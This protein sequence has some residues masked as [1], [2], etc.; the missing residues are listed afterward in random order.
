[1]FRNF[2]NRIW[3]RYF[4]ESNPEVDARKHRIHEVIFESHTPQGKL[5]DVV[6]FLVIIASVLVVMLESIRDLRVHYGSFFYFLEW[7]F[8]LFFTIEYALRVYC[9]KKP[10]VY[11]F[12]FF[13][14]IDLLA[15]LP[16]YI[17]W[18][19]PGAQS[20]LVIRILRLLRIFRVFRL[21]QYFSEGKY[22]VQAM[23]ASQRKI[24]V[25]MF[26]IVLMVTVFGSLMYLIEGGIPDSG[27]TS[28]PRSIYWAIV[29]LTT[30][31]YG[32]ITPVTALGQF[33]SAIVMILGYAVIAVPTGIVSA[34]MMR[35]QPPVDITNFA[36]PSCGRE[37][38]APDAV[39]CKYCGA[40]LRENELPDEGVL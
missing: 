2:I 37:G 23:K 29:T 27:F 33:I 18:L 8:T 32:D 9:L 10:K 20:L 19:L 16:T 17:S 15:I 7:A 3:H 11:V 22:M 31:G 39:Y 21:R 40:H 4:D 24:A 6:L 1:M 30:V 36:C 14:I 28:I 26:F 13:G 12:S 34:E 25:F 5:F 38:H 35:T